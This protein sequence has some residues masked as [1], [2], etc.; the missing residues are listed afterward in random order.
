MSTEFNYVVKLDT[1]SVMGSLAEVR[2]QIGMAFGGAGGGSTGGMMAGLERG[3]MSGFGRTHG[4]PAMA[5]DPHYGQVHASTTRGQENA[6][7][8]HGL[9]AAEAM[10]PPGV[11]AY[12]Y[13]MGLHS[14]AIDRQQ[15]ARHQAKMA[16]QSTF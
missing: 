1:T 15:N 8:S 9:A 11:S 10:R 7:A 16:A 6:V 5:Y 14:N 3:I 12:E 13:A 2:N 4:D